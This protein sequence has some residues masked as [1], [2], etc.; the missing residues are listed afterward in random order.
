MKNNY[1]IAFIIFIGLAVLFFFPSP[2]SNFL[3]YLGTAIFFII[4]IIIIFN[5]DK[6]KKKL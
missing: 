3:A 2:Q 6:I 5:W 1:L 4:I